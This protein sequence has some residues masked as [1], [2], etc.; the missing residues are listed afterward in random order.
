[1]T[2]FGSKLALRP[3]TAR[4]DTRSR[5]HV[6]FCRVVAA[7]LAM[8][9][10][11]CSSGSPQDCEGLDGIKFVC[12]VPAPEDLVAIP[13]TRW[14]I[15]SS[16][17]R[18]G[19]AGGLFLID[20]RAGTA[21]LVDFGVA[22]QSANEGAEA[23]FAD[24]CPP[25]DRAKLITHGVSLSM[26]ETGVY[27][28]LVV[29]H[30]GREAIEL[31]AVDLSSGE[32]KLT[33]IDCVRLPDG[34]EGNSV[35]GLPD[36]GLLVTTLYDL[37]DTS[38]PS[39]IEKLAAGKPAG[40]VYQWRP[41]SGFSVLPTPSISGPNGIAI[42]PDGQTLFLAGWGDRLLRRIDIDGNEI[43][44]SLELG[45]LPDNLHWTPDGML[46]AAGQDIAVRDLFSCAMSEVSSSYCARSYSVTQ[47]DPGD[48]T[49][50]ESW[51]RSVSQGFGDSTTA[52]KV[53]EEIWIGSISGDR[54]AAIEASE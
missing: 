46:L 39:R 18:D 10:A 47:I 53:G 8:G 16:M 1:M 26:A 54:V 32:P 4:L 24:A 13:N 48:F 6:L 14:I 25:P 33:W 52:V 43:S 42:S 30:G 15:A 3:C 17:P 40:A 11:T 45:F 35:V 27:R 9:L 5:P 44:P 49:I 23:A 29:G 21:E 31:F 20:T 22:P 28:L 41:G 51:A 7:I 38:W 50:V 36:G 37:G 2:W 34:L 12:G 19:T